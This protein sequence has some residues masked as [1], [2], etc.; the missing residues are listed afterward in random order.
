MLKKEKYTIEAIAL[1]L[2]ISPNTIKRYL[3]EIKSN[4]EYFETIYQERLAN[5]E[6][7]EAERIENYLELI[8]KY[9]QKK[10]PEASKKE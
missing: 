7:I 8:K 6:R 2:E 4:P 5:D 1:E 9:I 10:L 3:R